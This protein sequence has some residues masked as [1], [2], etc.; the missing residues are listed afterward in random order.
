MCCWVVLELK[1]N[2][3]LNVLIWSNVTFISQH[4]YCL[5][6]LSRHASFEQLVPPYLSMFDSDG[7]LWW[8][9]GIWLRSRVGKASFKKGVQSTVIFT[10]YGNLLSSCYY[11]PR[12]N[13]SLWNSYVLVGTASFVCSR[14]M[15]LNKLNYTFS[16]KGVRTTAPEQAIGEFGYDKI[17]TN[18]WHTIWN[19]YYL[20]FATRLC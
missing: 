14:M 19:L 10:S 4:G 12:A 17:V 16:R 8:G 18:C 1:V 13:Q 2:G 11:F 3:D 15:I 5:L 6:P 20:P 9:M 7:Q